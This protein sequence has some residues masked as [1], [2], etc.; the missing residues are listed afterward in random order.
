[1]KRIAVTFIGL[2]LL[3]GFVYANHFTP[4]W[5][6]Q[7]PYLAM[8]FFVSAAEINGINLA[9]GDE[10]GIFDRGTLVGAAMLTGPISSYPYQSVPI[11][12]SMT[13]GDVP[14]S[15]VPGQFVTL[16]VWK[17]DTL[18]EY[19]YPEMSVWF[20][21]ASQAI[22]ET[23]GDSFIHLI[24]WSAPTGTTSQILTPPPGPGG[25]Y[26]NNT[27]FAQAGVK[28][29]QIWINA[30]GGGT[31]TAYSF[32]TPTLDCTFTATPPNYNPNL[33]WFIDTQNIS[34]YATAQYPVTVS[35][36]IAGLPGVENPGGA[37]LYRRSIHGTGPFT[38]VPAV[39]DPTTGYLTAQVTALGEFIL[40]LDTTIP[41]APQFL[42]IERIADGF[43]LDWSAVTGAIGYKIYVSDEPYYGYLF[44]SATPDTESVLGD[45]FLQANGVN[46]ARSFFRVTAE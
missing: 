33:G 12:V 24:S 31:V 38:E 28:I 29:D 37:V 34:Y 40:M 43:R 39:Y 46:P 16:K 8:N 13:G 25:G 9:A 3:T 18:T 11:N 10:I 42:T 1:V 2:I 30:G 20:D 27:N 14:G 26:V 5:W 6:G 45:A 36:H 17:A 7:N 23:Q 35:F 22:F 4:A 44:L 19:S 15:A 41:P 32:N 21:D